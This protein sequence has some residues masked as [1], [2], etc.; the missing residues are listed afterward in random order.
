MHTGFPCLSSIRTPLKRPKQAPEAGLGLWG[1]EISTQ[2]VFQKAQLRLPV[3][4]LT[5]LCRLLAL[6]GGADGGARGR[7]SHPVLR[8]LV[9]SLQRQEI[10]FFSISLK[11]SPERQRKRGVKG[12]GKTTSFPDGLLP[13]CSF[14]QMANSS[15]AK[16]RGLALCC[17]RG[18]VSL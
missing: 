17:C 13:L 4:T 7:A 15:R 11:S 10:R 9:C 1:R 5:R 14:T 6:W 8:A 18:A 12:K 2:R 16:R 3:G